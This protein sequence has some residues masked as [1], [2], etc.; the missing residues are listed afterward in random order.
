MCTPEPSK[1]GHYASSI[2]PKIYNN[3]S[4]SPNTEK[5]H[6]GVRTIVA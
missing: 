4:M 5:L 1:C 2:Q 3:S 6:A